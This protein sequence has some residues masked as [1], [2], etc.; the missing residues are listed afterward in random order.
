MIRFDMFRQMYW[1]RL[2]EPIRFTTV[3]IVANRSFQ[4]LQS[5]QGN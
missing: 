5:I 2:K 3:S 4:D 1:Y